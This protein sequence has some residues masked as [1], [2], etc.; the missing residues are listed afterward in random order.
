MLSKLKT[1]QRLLSQAIAAVCCLPLSAAV[2]AQSTSNTETTDTRTVSLSEIVVTAQKREERLLDAPLSVSAL[3]ADELEARRITSIKDLQDGAIPSLQVLPLSGRASAV[4]LSM[5]GIDSGDPTQISQ[6]P[7]FGMYID[8]VYL[9]R[10]QGLGL[11][12]MD[13][14]R[15]E[16]MRGPQGTLFGRN[17]VGGAMNIVSKRPSGEFQ[18]RQRAG[19]GNYGERNLRT[20]IDFQQVGDVSLKID[21]V[22]AKR[23][24]WVKN[25]FD[26]PGESYGYD[27]MDRYGVKLS[28][29]WQPADTVDVL[30]AY[31]KSQDKS[32]SGYPHIR[33]FV[34]SRPQSPLV[35]VDRDRAK[36]ARVGAPLPYSIANV[37]GHTLRASYDLNDNIRLESI[38]ALR[39]LTQTQNDQWAS[40]F[41]GLTFQRIG[42]TG[43]LSNAGVDQEQFS[44]ELQLVGSAD[45]V[46]YVIGAFFYRETADDF[47]NDI[48]TMRFVDG[49]R[50]LVPMEPYI[51]SPTR[52]STLSAKSRAVFAQATW[53]PPVL[54][55]RLSLTTGL[56]YTDDYKSGE[57]TSTRGV[58]PNPPR[59]FNFTSDRVDPA[60]TVA[61][62]ASDEINTYIRWATA[63]RAGGANSRSTQFNPFGEEQVTALE[64]GV[65]TEFWDNRA[66]VNVS[67]YRSDYDDRWQIFFNPTNPSFNETFNSLETAKVKGIELDMQFALTAGLDV[68]ASYSHTDTYFPP[69]TNPFAPTAERLQQPQNG[70]SPRHAASAGL[71]YEF[72]RTSF[73]RI[74]TNLD[75]NYSGGHYIGNTKS[76]SY[77]LLNGRV[78]L[79]D[80]TLGSS[81]LTLETSLWMRNITN[82]NYDFFSFVLDG[83]GF[84]GADVE[85]LGRPRTFGLEFDVRF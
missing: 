32:T 64:V 2:C 36:T 72:P 77:V 34:D 5:R 75:A 84:V 58:R 44:Q 9:G 82:K 61:Y 85:F 48:I 53:T 62:R 59:I 24:G 42:L 65:K 71:A 50:S 43:R 54:D 56:R 70:L 49:G 39:E 46:D 55:D 45:R 60:F 51:V 16:V 52:S 41:F 3:T 69:L 22:V 7:S 76:A 14:E 74:R 73:G 15:I 8:G 57:L 20:N 17:A 12:M 37:E 19:I 47:A 21:G 79:G 18:V 23:D 63:Y 25:P 11:E 4:S 28:A 81:G 80:L 68:S 6:D 31:E 38:T 13:I 83:P 66:R 78:S 27:A 30:Y 29:L 33:A 67:A 40:S 26:R 10:V 35:V 1:D